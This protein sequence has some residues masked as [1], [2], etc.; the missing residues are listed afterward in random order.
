[1]RPECA[2]AP[3]TDAEPELAEQIQEALGAGA[4]VEWV[5]AHF[6]LSRSEI[7]D[8]CPELIEDDFDDPGRSPVTGY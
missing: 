4:S 3:D 5:I 6:H 1:M 2:Q 7:E 8:L